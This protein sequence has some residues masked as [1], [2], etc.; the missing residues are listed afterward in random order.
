[1]VEVYQKKLVQ[2]SLITQ[3]VADRSTQGS[4]EMQ[5]LMRS[6]ADFRPRL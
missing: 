1:M 5:D 4:E 3:D 2:R 6:G